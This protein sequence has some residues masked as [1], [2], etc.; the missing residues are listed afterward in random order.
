[1]SFP[2]KVPFE[3]VSA[4]GVTQGSNGMINVICDEPCAMRRRRSMR[5]GQGQVEMVYTE[6]PDG[7]KVY[8]RQ[9][10][11]GSMSIMITKRQIYV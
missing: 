9:M 5:P 6:M 3:I 8:V 11:D 1:M 7:L 4:N 10:E 2:F